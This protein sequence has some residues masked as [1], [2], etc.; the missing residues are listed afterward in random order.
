M[1]LVLKAYY[2]KSRTGDLTTL[3]CCRCSGVS[4]VSRRSN[5]SK[6]ILRFQISKTKAVQ[7]DDHTWTLWAEAMLVV[8]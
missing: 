3:L 4:G 8:A 1:I 5:I 7:K 2:Y 6:T